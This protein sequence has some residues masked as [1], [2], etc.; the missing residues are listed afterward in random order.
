MAI[1]RTVVDLW[2]RSS[3]FK[4]ASVAAVVMTIIVM[5]SGGGSISRSSQPPPPP[6]PSPV[7][8]PP[9][10]DP[11]Y[12]QCK[13]SANPSQAPLVVNSGG[14]QPSNVSVVGGSPSDG[15]SVE[16]QSRFRQFLTR[17]DAAD[18]EQRLGE[19]CAR[20]Q[21]ATRILQQQDYAYAACFTDGEKKL[22]QAQQCSQ[23]FDASE[24]RFQ[25]LLEAVSAVKADASAQQV[26][27]LSQ[28]RKAMLPFD[29]SRDRWTEIAP[30]LG[31]GDE[32]IETIAASDKRIA[33][34]VSAYQAYNSNSGSDELQNLVLANTLLPLDLTR[35]DTAQEKILAEARK[36]SE[37]LRESDARLDDVTSALSLLQSGADNA[38]DAL[39]SSVSSLLPFDETRASDLQRESI[40]SAKAETSAF[41]MENLLA[42]VATFDPPAASPEQHQ[43]LRNLREV[44]LRHGGILEPSVE[45]QGALEVASKATA[46]L[47]QSDQRLANINKV[48]TSYRAAGPAMQCSLVLDALNAITQFDRANMAD[49]DFT[50][51]ED[52]SEGKKICVATEDETLTLT[53]PVFIAETGSSKESGRSAEA[54]RIQLR[55]AGFNIVNAAEE[56]AVTFDL[57][58]SNLNKVKTSAG[59]VNVYTASVSMGLEGR[60]RISGAVLPVQTADGIG[61][62]RQSDSLA[63]DDAIEKLVC[64]VVMITQNGGEQCQTE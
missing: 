13:P 56:S 40:L 8:P 46:V 18:R 52:L 26:A 54:L 48:A 34:L 6:V 50:A 30:E 36:A 44:L 61:R 22:V 24:K 16:T 33:N 11:K 51:F 12:A 60:W 29:T 38:R 45:Q 64:Q 35:L 59:S 47:D 23:D 62:G 2:R 15:M 7:P 3:P 58:V 25:R 39:V 5:L 20:M 17:V 10:V 19:K 21:G 57:T 1:S 32:A 4:I 63:I 42:A 53:V 49:D 43:N 28:M 55:S 41:A 9:P 14:Q 37:K 27:T 31:A